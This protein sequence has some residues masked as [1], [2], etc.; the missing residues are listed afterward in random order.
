MLATSAVR[1]CPLGRDGR[2][3]QRGSTG[4][5]NGRRRSLEKC[6]CKER[7]KVGIWPQIFERSELQSTLQK[8]AL[9]DWDYS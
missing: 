2:T 7:G 3:E 8:E 5:G 9:I 1:A 6:T 4:N